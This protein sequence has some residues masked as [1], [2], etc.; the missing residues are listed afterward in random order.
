MVIH[1]VASVVVAPGAYLQPI[2]WSRFA[3]CLFGIH[4]L[5]LMV[6]ADAVPAF[7]QQPVM[8]RAQQHEVVGARCTA[9]GPMLHVM[10]LDI[11]RV[12]VHDDRAA[13]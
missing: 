2:P 12:D 4:V 6:P 8:L 9:V 3:H 10:R 5:A 11:A 7:V 13:L 1:R